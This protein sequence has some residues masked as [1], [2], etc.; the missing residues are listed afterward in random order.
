MSM[1]DANEIRGWIKGY[2]SQLFDMPEDEIDV[3]APLERYGLDST[4]A[5]GL[6]GDL[7]EWLEC[8]IDPQIVFDYPTI[9][10]L[11]KHLAG[12]VAEPV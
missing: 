7:G 9:A 11:A 10:A 6:T 3:H 5:A 12:K 8:S 1:F 2:L 4:A